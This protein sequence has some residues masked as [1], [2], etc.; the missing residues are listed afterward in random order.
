MVLLA[1][2][3]SS[4]EGPGPALGPAE[5]AA[6]E[7][8]RGNATRARKIIGSMTGAKDDPAALVVLACLALEDGFTADAARIAARLRDLRPKALEGQLIEALAK[9]RKARPRGDWLSAG[10]TALTEV[11]PPPSS[12]PLLDAAEQLPLAFHDGLTPFPDEK[13]SKLRASDAFVARWAWPRGPDRKPSPALVEAAVRFANADERPLVHLAALDV[14]NDV[15]AGGYAGRVAAID[16][17]RRAIEARLSTSPAGRLRLIGVMAREKTR[18]VEESEIVAFES[19]VAEPLPPTY[20]S[21][22]AELYQILDQVDRCYAPSLAFGAAVRLGVAPPFIIGL[23]D[24]LKRSGL[25]SAL[26]ERLA[27]AL[28][29]WADQQRREGTILADMLA[30]LALVRA[31]DLSGDGSLKDRA[32]AIK[33]EDDVLRDALRCLRPLLRLPIPSLQRAWA[34]QAAAERALA[35]QVVRMGLS[36]PEPVAPAPDPSASPPEPAKPCPDDAP[37]QPKAP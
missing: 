11:R 37:A 22:F 29:R 28:V 6:V 33:A 4:A 19:A 31:A 5:T 1:S 14:L 10:L 21:D 36:C 3:P 16:S 34:L 20:A 25:S 24:R 35:Q 30:G 9:E 12:P 7:L 17:G 32:Y 26:R 23:G 18:P 15:E 13:A 8:L 27:A 2:P